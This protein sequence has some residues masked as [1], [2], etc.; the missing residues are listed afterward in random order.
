MA[1]YYF[2]FDSYP[3]L[4]IGLAFVVGAVI[5]SFLNVVIYRVPKKMS[6]VSPGSHCF[7]C[8]TALKGIDNI[9]I[10][11]YLMLKGRCRHCGT[12]YSAQ[13]MVIELLTAVGTAAMA[14]FFYFTYHSFALVLISMLLTWVTITFLRL[15]QP[16]WSKPRK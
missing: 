13:Y 5:G 2:V 1:A 15:P 9:P 3:W 16:E 4:F 14:A 6:V 11:S 12:P 7:H 8:Q 10:V